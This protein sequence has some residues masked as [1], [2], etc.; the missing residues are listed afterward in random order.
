VNHSAAAS[1][2]VDPT[3]AIGQVQLAKLPGWTAARQ[4]NAAFLDA[5]LE[6]VLVP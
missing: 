4:A 3:A 2:D 6:A 5:N 1:A